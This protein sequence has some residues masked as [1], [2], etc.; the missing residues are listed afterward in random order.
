MRTGTE[1]SD[2]DFISFELVDESGMLTNAGVLLA[3]ESPIRHS[4]LFCTHWYGL[5]KASGN[6]INSLKEA[7]LITPVS[8]QGKGKYRFTEPQ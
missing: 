7:G 2:S 4:R 6:L 5:D 3:D 8:G 1:L